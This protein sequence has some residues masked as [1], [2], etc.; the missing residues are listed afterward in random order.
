MSP[1]VNRSHSN[2]VMFWRE[3]YVFLI[4]WTLFTM[5][6][7]HMQNILILF[8][9][10]NISVWS[11]LINAN[12]D[13]YVTEKALRV[14]YHYECVRPSRVAGPYTYYH[15]L[16]SYNHT[17]RLSAI[18]HLTRY[19]NEIIERPIINKI[20]YLYMYIFD[21]QSYFDQFKKVLFN[22]YI[23][24]GEKKDSLKCFIKEFKN[25]IKHKWT[26]IKSNQKST[27]EKWLPK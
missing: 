19:Y 16:V 23:P 17:S 13:G 10:Y 12:N 25:V 7:M 14:K 3:C 1:Q 18:H 27:F 24:D 8:C 21:I 15:F 26:D 5:W 20:E 22:N 9:I 2:L 4:K 11:Y 6:K